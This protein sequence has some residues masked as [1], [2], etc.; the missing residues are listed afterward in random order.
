[1]M[2][3]AGLASVTNSQNLNV[4]FVQ[5]EACRFNIH[6]CGVFDGPAAL[7]RWLTEDSSHSAAEKLRRCR[8][9]CESLVFSFV[10]S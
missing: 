4:Q 9:Q 6:L 10:S 5:F 1:M 8:N 3:F 2:F 7:K